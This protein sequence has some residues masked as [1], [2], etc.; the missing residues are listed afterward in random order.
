MA[1]RSYSGPPDTFSPSFSLLCPWIHGLFPTIEFAVVPSPS[2]PNSGDPGAT[3]AH[4]S[5]NSSDL[6]VAERSSAARSRSPL[7]GLIPFD[8]FRSNDLDRGY[9]IVHACPTP[10]ACL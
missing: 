2:L 6:T 5:H 4:A 1:H 3:L 9:L 8:R 7:P 10:L